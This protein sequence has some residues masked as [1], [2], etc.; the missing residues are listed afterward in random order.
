MLCARAWSKWH[1][2]QCRFQSKIE[3]ME[4]RYGPLFVIFSRKKITQNKKH[5]LYIARYRYLQIFWF[6]AGWRRAWI[7]CV[8]ILQTKF[9]APNQIDTHVD[10]SAH[11]MPSVYLLY[12]WMKA[13]KKKLAHKEHRKKMKFNANF[14][15]TNYYGRFRF[16]KVICCAWKRKWKI[17][18][19]CYKKFCFYQRSLE[20]RFS[21]CD[22]LHRLSCRC[23]SFCLFAV[24]AHWSVCVRINQHKIDQNFNEWIGIFSLNSIAHFGCPYLASSNLLPIKWILKCVVI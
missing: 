7:N 18:Y 9:M 2:M 1:R 6:F 4:Q 22:Y 11:K 24:D 19:F 5:F 21:M 17:M 23:R 13:Q 16:W 20:M 14:S 3:N 10:I 15:S 12:K 8:D